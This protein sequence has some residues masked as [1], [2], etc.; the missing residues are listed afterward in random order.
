MFSLII[1]VYRNEQSLDDLL[2]ELTKLSAQMRATHNSAM[3]VVFVVDGSPDN[4]YEVLKA[5][6]PA[7]AFS[8]QLL[9]HSRNFGSFA[10]IRSGLGVARGEYMGVM[11]ADLQEPTSLQ[12]E[13]LTYLQGGDFDVA[14]GTRTS[15][16]DP[17][18]TALASQLFWWG[19]RA[20]VNKAIPRG[21]VDVFACN[22]RFRDELLKLEESNT[23][24]VGLIFWLGFRRVEVGYRRVTR[25][26]G[27]SAWSLSRRVAYLLDSVFSFTDLPIRI[28]VALG[29][30]GLTVSLVGGAVIL[31]SRIVGGIEVPGYAATML[32]LLFFGG[33]NTLGLGIVGSYTWRAFENTKARPLAIVR[34]SV[35]FAGGAT[36]EPTGQQI[37]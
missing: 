30:V 34:T 10:A 12:I 32:T 8:S 31:I 5:R 37:P 33:L 29:L 35:S 18:S 1:P 3:E 9:L 24:L 17:A 28:L 36:A 22:R 26:Y 19:Y 11:A 20:L 21:G 7:A 4:C 15:R 27:K 13:F 16:D 25:K 6:L 14:V 23:S 2:L